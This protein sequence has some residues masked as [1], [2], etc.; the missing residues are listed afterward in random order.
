M[1]ILSVTGLNLGRIQY[2]DDID[3]PL[4]RRAQLTGLKPSTDYRIYLTASTD[5]GRGEAI[6][7]DTT[8]ADPG[9][10]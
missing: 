3:G 10:K 9:S 6:F 8:T 7:M 1:N 5:I 4:A 2:R